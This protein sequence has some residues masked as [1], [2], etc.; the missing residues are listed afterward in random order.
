M[1]QQLLLVTP[2]SSGS[3]LIFLG[4]ES[5]FMKGNEDDIKL[6]GNW[7]QTKQYIQYEPAVIFK[8]YLI[9]IH[10]YCILAVT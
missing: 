8:I 1:G 9:L 7:E 5:K 2:F 10:F 6:F 3:F 4:L